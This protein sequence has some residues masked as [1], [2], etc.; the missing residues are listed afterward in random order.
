MPTKSVP[1]TLTLAA[2]IAAVLSLSCNASAGGI[3]VDGTTCTLADAITAANTDTATGGCNAGSG[4]DTLAIMKNVSVSGELPLITSDMR[5][6]GTAG[7]PPSTQIKGDMTHRLFF[8]GANDGNTDIAPN[9]LFRDLQIYDGSA[10]GGHGHGGGAGAGL[11]GALFEYAGVVTLQNVEAYSNTANGGAGGVSTVGE[12]GDGGAGMSGSGGAGG[13]GSPGGS[14]TTDGFGGGGGGGGDAG[15]SS[16]GDGGGTYF[17]MGGVSGGALPQAG[18]FGGGAGGGAGQPSGT[19]QS[20]ANGGFGGGG[21]GGGFANSGALPGYG[22]F[23]GFGAGGGQGGHGEGGYS[24]GG[25]G[26]FGGGGGASNGGESGPGGFGGGY[27]GS[28]SSGGGAG[29]GG[30]VFVRGGSLNVVDSRLTENAAYAGAAGDTDSAPGTARGG[31]IFVLDSLTGSNGNSQGYPSK[32][33]QVHGCNN[34]LSNNFAADA[35][36]TDT[37]NVDTYGVSET[38]LTGSACPQLDEIFFDGYEPQP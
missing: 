11:G 1:R 13:S 10:Q 16:G 5:I 36:S 23:G 22:G 31:A 2:A 27:G 34:V 18:G 33:P 8:V 20:G 35:L 25:F 29:F 15:G 4:V 9:V 17:G 28:A 26:G 12:G 30:A 38:E 32:L 7:S 6:I 19:A 14:G 3:A 37:D 21:G 24:G